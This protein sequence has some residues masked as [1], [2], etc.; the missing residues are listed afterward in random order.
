MAGRSLGELTLREKIG[1]GGFAV[2]YRAHQADLERDAVVKILH[3]RLA[4]TTPASTSARELQAIRTALVPGWHMRTR[5][6]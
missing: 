5:A 2:M 1:E 4:S 6:G 3:T